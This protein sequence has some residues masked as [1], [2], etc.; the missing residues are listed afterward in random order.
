MGT[1]RTDLLQSI[2]GENV[3]GGTTMGVGRVARAP[4][5]YTLIS[6]G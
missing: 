5:G 1:D 3:S 6:R 4:D 2:I